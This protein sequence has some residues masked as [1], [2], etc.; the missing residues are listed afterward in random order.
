MWA[1]PF[2]R[3]QGSAPPIL[4]ALFQHGQRT[5]ASRWDRKQPVLVKLTFLVERPPRNDRRILALEPDLKNFTKSVWTWVSVLTLV[6]Q[7][8]IF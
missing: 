8:S 4:T 6:D 1:G 3:G 7:T 5:E 2:P